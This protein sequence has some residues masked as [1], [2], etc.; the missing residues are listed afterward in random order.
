MF[1]F[2]HTS[3]SHVNIFQGS[4]TRVITLR[5]L[6]ITIRHEGYNVFDKTRA[7]RDGAAK[8]PKLS[9]SPPLLWSCGLS[10]GR[11]YHCAGDWLCLKFQAFPLTKPHIEVS[12]RDSI[13]VISG[14]RRSWGKRVRIHSR[15]LT[16][17]TCVNKGGVCF[18][19]RQAGWQNAWAYGAGE[20][21]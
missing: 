2:L 8:S 6:G 19:V 11:V 13:P 15:H 18:S 4:K 16:C 12:R 14:R 7:G 20:S 1:Y 10:S 17:Q 9:S 3:H 21:M 5:F